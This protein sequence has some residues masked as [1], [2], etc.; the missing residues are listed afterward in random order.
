MWTAYYMPF[1]EA[2]ITTE[3]VKN[4]FRF[5][6]QYYDQ[7]TGLHYNYHRYYDP[8]VG[9]YISA[10]PIGIKGGINLFAYVENNPVNSIDPMGLSGCGP[11]ERWG[12]W[13]IPDY[14]G[15]YPFKECCDQHDD[16]YGCDGKKAGKSQ[17]DCDMKFCKC[18]IGKCLENRWNPAL[19]SIFRILL[20]CSHG[21]E[22]FI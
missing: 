1:G 4:N 16:C 20:G 14:P 9:R 2:V 17:R 12:D 8:A 3:T 10:D 18:L 7:E 21:W 6:G 19:L 15:G 5:P 13:L 11:G 22:R